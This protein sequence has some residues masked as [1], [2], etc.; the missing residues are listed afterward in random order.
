M[1]GKRIEVRFFSLWGAQGGS[2]SDRLPSSPPP[3][4]VPQV[5]RPAPSPAWSSHVVGPAQMAV[6]RAAGQE[7]W[8]EGPCMPATPCSST[9]GTAPQAKSAAIRAASASASWLAQGS[10]RSNVGGSCCAFRHYIGQCASTAWRSEGQGICAEADC[11][12]RGVGV[13]S[14]DRQKQ[15]EEVDDGVL[16]LAAIFEH[17][18]VNNLDSGQRI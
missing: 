1:F 14:R 12:Y 18:F 7:V 17:V 4:S 13:A 3:P 11:D 5:A 8:G 16:D 15:N 10:G 6:P 9:A 2:P